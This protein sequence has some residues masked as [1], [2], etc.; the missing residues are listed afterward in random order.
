MSALCSGCCRLTYGTPRRALA[1]QLMLRTRSPGTRGAGLRTRCPRPFAGDLAAE[2]GPAPQRC[3]E[4][5]Q[6]VDTWVGTQLRRPAERALER[7]GAEPVVR[8][9]D[10]RAGREDAPPSDP[11]LERDGTLLPGCEPVL[12]RARIRPQPRRLGRINPDAGRGAAV[13]DGDGRAN[14]LTLQ[15]ALAVQLQPAVERERYAHERDAEEHHERRREHREVGAAEGERPD[16]PDRRE[17]RVGTQTRREGQ[18]HRQ[19]GTRAGGTGQPS[20]Q[21]RTTSSSVDSLDPQLRAQHD[22]VRQRR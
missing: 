6:P 22:P 7:K 5:V 2:H 3:D 13:A 1:R 4:P 17:R 19:S 16:E 14:T 12:D 10:G 15:S 8:T 21:S 18:S 9:D 20:R 11:Q